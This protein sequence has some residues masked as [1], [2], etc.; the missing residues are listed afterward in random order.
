MFTNIS[1]QRGG[2]TMEQVNSV[3]PSAFVRRFLCLILASCMVFQTGHK[4]NTNAFAIALPTLGAFALSVSA[5]VAWDVF[6][7]DLPNVW[8]YIFNNDDNED[9]NDEDYFLTF[10]IQAGLD[11]DDYET[12]DDLV[13]DPKFLL[14]VDALNY[15]AG[16]YIE[17]DDRNLTGYSTV[18][19][20]TV[21]AY[22]NSWRLVEDGYA[23]DYY[24]GNTKY[25]DEIEA[26]K[27]SLENG[28]IVKCT[29]QIV[30]DGSLALL[31]NVMDGTLGEENQVMNY[32]ITYFSSNYFS[33]SE[34]VVFNYGTLGT[35]TKES[36]GTIGNSGALYNEDNKNIFK[37]Y[38]GFFLYEYNGD[39]LSDSKFLEPLTNVKWTKVTDLNLK[40]DTF[41]TII[42]YSYLTPYGSYDRISS[43]SYIPSRNFTYSVN[44][45]TN[46][47]DYFSKSP[48]GIDSPVY[49][50]IINNYTNYYVDGNWYNGD[51]EDNSDNSTNNGGGSGTGDGSLSGDLNVHVDGELD[52]NV[53]GSI[54]VNVNIDTDYDSNSDSLVLW[55]LDIILEFIGNCISTAV[56]AIF[57]IFEGIIDNTIGKL[58]DLPDTSFFQYINE[59]F[60][61]L[62]EEISEFIT[63]SIFVVVFGGLIIKIVF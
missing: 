44:G 34:D 42:F 32:D 63:Y 52:H 19:G 54:D 21:N 7:P 24:T 57:E 50:S 13:N 48:E 1:D 59:M 15:N 37:Q 18:T 56:N 26:Q 11:P 30:E 28:K 2:A 47:T 25:L 3:A 27:N 31:Y 29:P 20:Q 17:S 39:Y 41:Y 60:D 58:F 38:F 35:S 45:V 49:T 46:S 53:D 4:N 8:S 61:F 43:Y 5:N 10:L 16:H 33:F 22:F 6:G 36:N 23:D 40:A 9:F 62:P 14:L 51:Y 12:F 55:I